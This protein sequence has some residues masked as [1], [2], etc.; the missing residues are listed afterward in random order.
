LKFGSIQR[1]F[2]YNGL[3]DI[4][5]IVSQQTPPI[6]ITVDQTQEIAPQV[7]STHKRQLR[8]TNTDSANNPRPKKVKFANTKNVPKCPHPI[9]FHYKLRS[10][11]IATLCDIE[12]IKNIKNSKINVT[13]TIMQHN[14]DNIMYAVSLS[15]I[16]K[17]Y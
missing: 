11:H 15:N 7:I 10:V 14:D 8:I 16:Y 12:K 4:I 13:A 17:I 5:D 1:V 3:N 2:N 6:V 9:S